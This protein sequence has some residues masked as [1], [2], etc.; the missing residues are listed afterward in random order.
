MPKYSGVT[1]TLKTSREQSDSSVEVGVE[2]SRGELLKYT[3]FRYAD[4][5]QAQAE[6]HTRC[7]KKIDNFI[8]KRQR[9]RTEGEILEAITTY[10]KNNTTLSRAMARAWYTENI[11][12]EGAI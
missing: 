4:A 9:K 8:A 11:A 10:F 12:D 1:Y 2:F 5:A 3:T 7:Q 6:F